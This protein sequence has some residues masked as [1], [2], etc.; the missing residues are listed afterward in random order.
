MAVRREPVVDTSSAWVIAFVVGVEEK[1]PPDSTMKALMVQFETGLKK[2]K[3]ATA[4][5]ELKTIFPADFPKK[6]KGA[7]EDD[8]LS[9]G[10]SQNE[11]E[12]EDRWRNL[13]NDL[14]IAF[15]VN[16]EF[17]PPHIIVVLDTSAIGHIWK[18]AKDT[19][20]PTPIV[21][22]I[23]HNPTKHGLL[24]LSKPGKRGTTGIVSPTAQMVWP[25]L[26]LLRQVTKCE[27]V[28]VLHWPYNRKDPDD[29]SKKLEEIEINQVKDAL[30]GL[31]LG[32]VDVE[33]NSEA[34]IDTELSKAVAKFGTTSKALYVVSGPEV[35]YRSRHIAERALHY[36]FAGVYPYRKFTWG[37]PGTGNDGGLMSYGSNPL[38]MV[39]RASSYVAR[40]MEFG[41]H[42][43]NP[44]DFMNDTTK[45]A[46]KLPME[47]PTEVEWV[48]NQKTA[49]ALGLFIDIDLLP[50]PAKPSST[51]VPPST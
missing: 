11:D 27:K 20:H 2:W 15:D 31:H 39:E 12:Q 24:D 18:W 30:T 49:K 1:D 16:R 10:K 34:D 38:A 44:K 8:D 47:G 19:D 9:P 32:F 33:V 17:L 42:R 13:S 29:S 46:E 4:S 23:S 45:F 26:D 14:S 21:L 7:G 3:E 6:K 36:G 48:L 35:A 41:D 37:E 51:T 40:I 25:R 22:A 28:A 50:T 5:Y 43:A